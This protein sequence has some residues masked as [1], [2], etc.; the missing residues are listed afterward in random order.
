MSTRQ[1]VLSPVMASAAARAL[2]NP[3]PPDAT[4]TQTLNQTVDLVKRWLDESTAFPPKG[5]AALLAGLLKDPK[6]LAFT[7]GFVDGVIRPEDPAVAGQTLTR[8]AK[9]IPAFVPWYMKMALKIGARVALV[10]PQV[11][12][13]VT[14]RVLRRMVGHL[15]IDARPKRLTAG[16]AHA[17][18]PNTRLNLNLLGEAVLGE[19]EADRRLEGTTRLLLRDDVDYISIKV[20]SAVA[21]HAPWSFDQTVARVTKRLTPLFELAKAGGANGPK[22]VNLDMEEFGDLD[23]TIAVFTGILDQ[24]HLLE[25][26]AGIVIQT[27]LPDAMAALE[28]LDQWAAARVAKGGARIKV[29]LVKG[30]NL[31][32][33]QMAASI[34]GWPVATYATKLETD[35]NYLRAL[36]WALTPERA[37]RLWFGVAG[38]NLFNIAYTWLL[39]GQRGV[40]DAVE[41]EMLLGMAQGQVE[42]VKAE[43]GS[44]RLYVP[45]V[46]PQ[47]FDVAIA[48]LIRRLEEGA[49]SDN[50]MSAVFEL[51]RNPELFSREEQRFLASVAALE[52]AMPGTN[53]VPDRFAAASKPTVDQFAETPDTDPAVPANRAWAKRILEQAP[54]SQL[55]TE[56]V[57]EARLTT[58]KAVDQ[59]VRA[60]TKAG[61]DWAAKPVT[62]RAAILHQAGLELEKRRADFLEIMALEAGKTLDQSDPE[63]SEGIDFAHYYANQALEL[64]Q[65]T[66]ASFQPHRLTVVAP[67]WNFPMSIPA[68]GVLAALATGSAVILKPAVTTRRTAAL[69]AEALWAAGV[70]RQVLGF[71]ALA[72]DKVGQSLIRHPL[73]DQVILTGAFETAELF[74]SWRP[75]LRLLAETSGKNAII[76]TPSADVNLAVKD[77]V[78]SAFAHAG[79]KCSACSLVILV[80]SMNQSRRFRD[81]L[82]DAVRSLKVGPGFDAE[83]T[84]GP[85]I[86]SPVAKLE[87]GLTN[88]EN[89]QNWVVRPRQ[90][91]AIG[92]LWSPGV[93]SGVEPFSEFHLVEYFGPVLGVMQA[94]DLAHAVELANAVEY[95]LTSGLHSLDRAEIEYWL[96]NIQAGNLYIN[97]SITGA[98]V[99]RQPFGGW[100]K[101]AVGAGAKAGGPNYLVG[102]GTWTPVEVLPDAVPS[103]GDTALPWAVAELLDAA[104][105]LLTDSENTWLRQAAALDLAEMTDRFSPADVCGLVAE[106]NVLRYVAPIEPVVIRWAADAPL[107]DLVR[108]VIAAMVAGAPFEVWADQPLP[109]ELQEEIAAHALALRQVSDTA[110]A[111][112]LTPGQPR[113]VRLLGQAAS[114][115]FQTLEGRPEVAVW[116]HIPTINGRLE[117]LPFLA[118]Q[119]VSVTAHRFGSPDP[120]TKNLV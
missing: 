34:H 93:R 104:A 11:V 74:R 32:M 96:D 42:A 8:L 102:L 101:S 119:A 1:P 35:T 19:R 113:R 77:V 54:R 116:D 94:R 50:F 111:T 48:Y 24:P 76:V 66:G 33:E 63:V 87:R 92:R 114:Q 16:I 15:V 36:N 4:D 109:Q 58:Q 65:V 69:V 82:V 103:P 14:R 68:G 91:D 9:D 46:S 108:V 85:L 70:P 73:V 107:V 79:Q 5:S 47:E 110:I 3:C 41:F 120:L 78:Y 44:I 62:E 61:P 53:K 90:L 99:R 67:P 38:H 52:A 115:L 118:E 83:T 84:M 112:S 39:A 22:F 64:D 59:L 13:P 37:E 100:K 43:V 88:L 71:A 98:I 12:V 117:L 45:V 86:S 57:K 51:N 72:D 30:A 25:L 23:M 75:D 49:A 2:P 105:D 20:S 80:G 106:H 95:G 10:M 89:G 18:G 81:Q 17:S 60:T 29:R 6:G 31:P 26:E 7:V 28:R 97:R 21:P 27:Y 55:G 40:R 56:S